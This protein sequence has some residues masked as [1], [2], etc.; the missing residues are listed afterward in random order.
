M[1]CPRITVLVRAWERSSRIFDVVSICLKKFE[2]FVPTSDAA[3]IVY[4]GTS[5]NLFL[6][7]VRHPYSCGRRPQPNNQ[8]IAHPNSNADL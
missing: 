8:F 5:S 2:A 3:P 7:K 1:E 6:G 4:L